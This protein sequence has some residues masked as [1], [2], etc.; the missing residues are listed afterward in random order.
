MKQKSGNIRDRF[1]KEKIGGKKESSGNR[2]VSAKMP[3]AG[4]H[5]DGG[6]AGASGSFGI[7][8]FV[9]GKAGGTGHY[10]NLCGNHLFWRFSGGKTAAEEKI[11]VGAF[12]GKPVLSD[13]GRDLTDRQPFLPGRGRGISFGA[14]ALRRGRYAGRHVQLG[15]SGLKRPFT[16]FEKNSFTNGNF[17]IYYT[18]TK[19]TERYGIH[20][21]HIKTL[22]TRDLKESMKKGGCG[23]CQ[24]SC[25]SAC[26]TSC[27]VGN[28][29]CEKLK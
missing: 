1:G 24:T 7:P 14:G 27:T 10:R 3:F 20:M 26:K 16:K 11:F 15:F 2:S 19:S 18:G 5:T 22:S 29:S 4:I 25:Q 23:E 12:G 8:L 13:T 9:I 17:M 21:K 6:A 28:Q